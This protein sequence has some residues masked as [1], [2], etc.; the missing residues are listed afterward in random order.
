MATYTAQTV[1]EQSPS[2]IRSLICSFSFSWHK[3]QTFLPLFGGNGVDIMCYL[4]W[5][6]LFVFKIFYVYPLRCTLIGWNIGRQIFT[7]KYITL[8]YWIL[9]TS[10][11]Q[12]ICSI[13]TGTTT[14]CD[15]AGTF[16][17]A[18]HVPWRLYWGLHYNFITT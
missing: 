9:K 17:R 15:P 5:Y 14:Y 4:S 10:S 7:F 2:L 13:F 3:W 12:F 6:M 8:Y 18:S 1:S 11:V 16:S